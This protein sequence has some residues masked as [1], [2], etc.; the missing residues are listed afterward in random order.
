[1]KNKII[2][3]MFS[4]YSIR[5][6]EY[7]LAFITI[8]FLTRTLGVERYGAINF[9]QSFCGYF[10]LV[11]TYSFH[12]LG[13]KKIA[14]CKDD[15]E[16]ANYFSAIFFSKV[17]L[18]LIMLMPFVI[19]VYGFTMFYEDRS[20]FIAA[21]MIIIGD[22]LFPVWFF[23]GIEEM[24]YI[25]YVNILARMITVSALFYF[26]SSKEDDV[27]AMICL[28][29]TN[30]IAGIFSMLIIYYKYDYV[31]KIV[32]FELITQQLKDGWKVF[33]STLAVNIY[34]SSN[35][36]FLG[37][38]TDNNIVG[39][40]SAA[41]KI[42]L[43][44]KNVIDTFSAAI[45]P[46]TS[47]MFLVSEEQMFDF[48]IIWKKRICLLGIVIFLV[49]FMGS[50]EIITL[51]LGD[52]YV[53]AIPLLRVLIFIP[54]IVTY[55]NIY[56]IQIMIT[57]GWTTLYSRI[58]LCSAFLNLIIVLPSIYFWQSFGVAITMVSTELFVALYS[59]LACKRKGVLV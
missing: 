40:F 19:S 25:T 23:Q 51:I 7:I 42:M 44:A 12:I 26:V 52:D 53:N 3:N 22:I 57:L 1:M 27:I 55:T 29:S 15:D 54:L 46:H 20:L 16:R 8:P 35:T 24:Q 45:Y 18:A 13:P 41:Q 28:S 34:T 5:T 30:I 38:M 39:I 10:F 9:A 36:F 43:A 21:F 33:Y 14:M 48:L 2:S 37:V 47:R 32:S 56:M 11:I 49:G 6:M 4:L 58:V 31:F 50:S 17:F 59:Y